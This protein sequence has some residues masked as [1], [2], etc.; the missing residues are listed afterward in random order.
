MNMMFFVFL[1]Y[2]KISSL[3]LENA[4]LVEMVCHNSGAR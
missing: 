2:A 1:D 3:E 4:P